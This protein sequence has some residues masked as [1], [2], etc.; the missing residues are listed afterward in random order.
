MRCF[1]SNLED[2][3][4]S[5]LKERI[6]TDNNLIK[7][8]ILTEKDYVYDLSVII[9]VS[10]VLLFSLSALSNSNQIFLQ[11]LRSKEILSA[12]S[13]DKMF[14]N[15]EDLYKVHKKLLGMFEKVLDKPTHLNIAKCFVDMV[16]GT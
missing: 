7:E 11:P 15:I 12:E 2:Q 16:C 8:I 9:E 14:A 13:L 6:K 10:L 3:S 5:E 1:L 4:T